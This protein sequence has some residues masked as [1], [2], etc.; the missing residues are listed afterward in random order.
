M[1][2]SL[3]RVSALRLLKTEDKAFGSKRV[4]RRPR[5]KHATEGE[6]HFV[7]KQTSLKSLPLSIRNWL[8]V[9]GIEERRCFKSKDGICSLRCV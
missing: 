7:Q 2:V 9:E 3:S 4:F 1:V 5:G 8:I 6:A